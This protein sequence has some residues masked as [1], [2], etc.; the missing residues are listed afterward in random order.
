MV[1]AKLGSG[2]VNTTATVATVMALNAIDRVISTGPAGG[3]T[4]SNKPGM[5]L[6]VEA[7]ITWQSGKAAEGRADFPRREG[8]ESGGV[9]GE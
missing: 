3:L 5:W 9:S 4:E 1:A 7:V 8:V 2:C 6:R